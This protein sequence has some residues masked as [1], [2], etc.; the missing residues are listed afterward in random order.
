MTISAGRA[1]SANSGGLLADMAA[2]GSGVALL[3]GFNIADHIRSGRLV[4]VFN[5]W[6]PPELWLTLYYPPPL[7][8]AASKDCL[9]LEI[10]RGAGCGSHGHVGVLDDGRPMPAQISRLPAGLAVDKLLQLPQV[11]VE[12]F[13]FC[14]INKRQVQIFRTGSRRSACLRDQCSGLIEGNLLRELR[15]TGARP[16]RQ[17]PACTTRC[18]HR[19]PFHHIAHLG[20]AYLSRQKLTQVLFFRG[21]R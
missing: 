5:G 20:T 2:D 18:L 10:F 14:Q 9:I 7:S 16:E 17:R 19:N 11:A 13:A 3:P 21:A 6:A 4:H 15:L 1:F 12:D 8:G